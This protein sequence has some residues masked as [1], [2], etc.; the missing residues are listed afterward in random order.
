MLELVPSLD[1]PLRLVLVGAHC[2]DVEIGAGGLLLDL[3]ARA[4]LGSA[5][6]LVLAS[7]PKREREARSSL[8][9]FCAPVVPTARFG[10]L[11]DGRLPGHWDAV[12]DL[13]QET[14][15]ATRPDVV[16]APS[17]ADA[18]QDHRLLG[19]LV[20][21]A[22][23]DAVVLHYEIPKWDG[24]LGATRPQVYWPLSPE[25][26]ERKWALLDE[27]YPSQRPH[28]W[29]RADTFSGLARLR[30]MECRAAYAE[31]FAAPKI[32][33]G[34]AALEPGVGPGAAPPG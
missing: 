30:G 3:A 13:L 12:K 24:D 5:D 10:G 14:A 16:L 21:T 25:L 1:R 26:V 31:A 34:V 23:R 15:A 17:P 2:D 20:R 11:P 4:A 32:V 6:A 28:D 7:T 33:L 18:H 19:E 22:F 8:A 27:H 29:W 9:A